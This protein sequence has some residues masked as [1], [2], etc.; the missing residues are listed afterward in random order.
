V[1]GKRHSIG[2]PG[3][4]LE[5][6]FQP[7][8]VKLENHFPPLMIKYMAPEGATALKAMWSLSLTLSGGLLRV[9]RWKET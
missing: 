3:R 5:I 9:S 8:R 4:V 1:D 6:A 7:C 2:K